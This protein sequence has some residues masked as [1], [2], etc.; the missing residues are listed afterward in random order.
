MLLS[1]TIAFKVPVEFFYALKKTQS[2]FG[3]AEVVRLNGNQKAYHAKSSAYIE[4][5]AKIQLGEYA[6]ISIIEYK[7]KRHI[8]KNSSFIEFHGLR[9]YRTDGTL[10]LLDIDKKIAEVIEFFSP[11]LWRIELPIDL[12]L[13]F[14]EVSQHFSHYFERYRTTLESTSAGST[15][16]TQYQLYCKTTK[17][18]LEV[19]VTRL[20]MKRNYK[21]KRSPI[22]LNFLHQLKEIEEDLKLSIEAELGVLCL[23]V[24]TP[25][26]TT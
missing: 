15:V 26:Q 23:N 8:R 10:F 5:M 14:E 25:L 11:I 4:N 16:A 13:P 3:E 24:Y 7:K 2:I 9:Q 6:F 12:A 18:K 20:E 21:R 22:K 19:A 17:D 1:D